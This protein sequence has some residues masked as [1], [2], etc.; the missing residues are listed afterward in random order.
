MN[1]RGAQVL[2]IAL[3]VGA[4][5]AGCGDEETDSKEE[6]I[7]KGDE[8]CALGTFEVGNRAQARYGMPSPPPQQA[9]QFAREVI[10]PTLQREVVAELRQ[11]TPPAGDEAKV[12]AIYDELERALDRL[13]SNPE[14]ITEPDA[15]GA[16]DEANRLA[17][18]YGFQQCGSS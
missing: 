14:L 17:Q 9:P 10:V 16:F 3:V 4:A 12:D 15:G 11:L 1:G 7:A 18:A 2:A 5:V 13:R 8:I 6:Y